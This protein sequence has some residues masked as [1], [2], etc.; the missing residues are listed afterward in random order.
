[1]LRSAANPLPP[2]LGHKSAGSRRGR[3]WSWWEVVVAVSCAPRGGQPGWDT[4]RP[5]SQRP[6]R[7]PPLPAVPKMLFW[8][9]QPEHYNQHSTGSYLR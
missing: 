5:R 8:H 2:G 1:M 4:S 7:A 9:T 3:D 6:R